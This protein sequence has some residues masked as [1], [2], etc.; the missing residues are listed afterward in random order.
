MSPNYIT[1]PQLVQDFY[2]DFFLSPV[3]L[4]LSTDTPRRCSV[5]ASSST[6]APSLVS[7]KDFGNNLT[8]GFYPFPRLCCALFLFSLFV[9]LPS[10]HQFGTN[11]RYHSV[12]QT[13][14]VTFE[15]KFTQHSINRFNEQFVEIQ[16][17]HNSLQLPS[18][19]SKTFSSSPNKT[20]A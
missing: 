14:K 7:H 9:S 12:S 8:P 18:S 11:L 2:L 1:T 3:F 19:T 17:I 10:L 20:H 13:I 6:Q 16:S 4:L 15:M 5:L